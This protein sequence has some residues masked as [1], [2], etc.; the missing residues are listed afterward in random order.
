[1]RKIYYLI[2]SVLISATCFPQSNNFVS[3]VSKKGTTAAAFLS[4]GQGVRAVSM[5]GAFVAVA[6]D[7][8]AIYWNPA[9]ITQLDGFNITFDHTNWIANIN[10]DYIA[11]TYG[12]GEFGTIGFS[13]TMSDI[14]EMAVTT[15]DEPEGTGEV[16]TA[17][18]AAFSLTYAR[19]LTDNFSIGFNPKFI[20]ENIW[21]MS[22]KAFAIDLGVQYTTPFDGMVLAM[23]ISNF[24]GKMQLSGNANVILYDPDPYNGGNNDKIPANIETDGWSLPLTYRVGVAY[25]PVHTDM[26]KL[27]IAADALH[28]SDNYESVN[29]GGEYVFHDIISIR[30]GYKSLFLKN[31]EESLTLGIGIK[32]L[33]LGNVALRV[34]Y[35]YENFGRFSNIQKFGVSISF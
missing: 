30:G 12:I 17:S 3:D 15:I 35:A 4:I 19:K 7:P 22:A 13:L 18:Q 24:G 23:S 28:P 6:D 20:I 11:G 16:F 26:H 27:T 10:Y 21:T 34:D 14:G 33:L 29:L 5:G 2:L 1:M 25:S 9:G 8:S 31:S 32:Q